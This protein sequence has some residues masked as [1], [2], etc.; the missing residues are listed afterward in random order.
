MS[1][2]LA[3]L[4]DP[5]FFLRGNLLLVKTK[6]K[7]NAVSPTLKQGVLLKWLPTIRYIESGILL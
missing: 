3:E 6:A 2:L 5:S 7:A 1:S 4:L